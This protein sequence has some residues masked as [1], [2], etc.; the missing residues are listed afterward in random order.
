MYYR[1]HFLLLLCVLYQLPSSSAQS[2]DSL[3]DA[4]YAQAH[5]LMQQ[6]EDESAIQQLD[7]A[8][9]L[10]QHQ[11][12]P[13]QQIIRFYEKAIHSAEAI[14]QKTKNDKYLEQAFAWT[15]QC[16]ALLINNLR[17][18]I[19]FVKSNIKIIQ[20]EEL[21]DKVV[22]DS[23]AFLEYLIGEETIFLFKI[24]NTTIQLEKI[25]RDIT[26]E[27]KVKQLMRLV[28]SPANDAS[29]FAE[30]AYQLYTYL[31]PVTLPQK[32]VIAPDG[33]LHYLPFEV[34][35][36]QQSARSNFK[37]LPYLLRKTSISYTY[38]ATELASHYKG[39][40]INIG[41]QFLGIAYPD[42]DSRDEVAQLNRKLDGDI[43]ITSE[44]ALSDVQQN[45]DDYDIIHLAING[46]IS[47]TNLQESGIYLID[48]QQLIDIKSLYQQDM[49]AS[50]VVLNSCNTDIDKASTGEGI[51]AMI[52]AL[53]KDSE[54][55]VTAHW[56]TDKTTSKDVM[57]RFYRY[58]SDKAPKDDAL[59][60]A[61]L[62][63]LSENYVNPKTAHP[64]YWASCMA[65][66][67]MLPLE[68]QILIEDFMWIAAVLILAL[69]MIGFTMLRKKTRVVPVGPIGTVLTANGG[70]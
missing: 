31:L 33:I 17:K 49:D 36:T 68:I 21:R 22:K 52:Q 62:D 60:Q 42:P 29:K 45:M 67:N 41:K 69:L 53:S 66:N 2:F 8:L 35:V 70:R 64:Y 5:E 28:S 19:D 25:K 32:C 27:K 23:V 38:S 12:L 44:N 9:R 3:T 26:L 37:T 39:L 40:P 55:I 48:N 56:M 63:Y 14:F 65:Y 51:T 61:K 13:R 59:R 30:V 34:L 4:L 47:D 54:S 50:M 57:K 10:I 7:E 11:S 1:H 6:S 20:L 43:L 16:K 24:T 46:I 58:L 18:K 15:E